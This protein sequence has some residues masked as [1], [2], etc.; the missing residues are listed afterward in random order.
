MRSVMF[1]ILLLGLAGM[2]CVLFLLSVHTYP[3][4]RGAYANYLHNG[5][6]PWLV[7]FYFLNEASSGIKSSLHV[8]DKS[9]GFFTNISADDS[10]NQRVISEASQS[11]INGSWQDKLRL[12]HLLVLGWGQEEK[13]VLAIEW[14][15]LSREQAIKENQFERWIKHGRRITVYGLFF[16]HITVQELKLQL[17]KDLQVKKVGS[18]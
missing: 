12:V 4:T 6:R 11:A 13:P 2:L 9:A 15:Y 8:Y 5:D 1:N 7:A 18:N 14:Y 3:Q 17:A 16:D 10:E